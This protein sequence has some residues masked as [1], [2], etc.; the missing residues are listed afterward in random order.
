MG[1]LAAVA[2]APLSRV[3]RYQEIFQ[4]AELVPVPPAWLW[5]F[6]IKGIK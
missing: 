5:P 1:Q 3:L 2:G 4:E 6:P